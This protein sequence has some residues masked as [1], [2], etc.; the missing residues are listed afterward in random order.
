MLRPARPISAESSG[1][2]EGGS[3]TVAGAPVSEPETELQVEPGEPEVDTLDPPLTA[4]RLP[5]VYPTEEPVVE[6]GN[7][8]VTADVTTPL[9]T[10][11][12]ANVVKI[13][14][15]LLSTFVVGDPTLDAAP[16][17][18]PETG[19]Q[20]EPEVDTL[21]GGPTLGINPGAAM[22][23]PVPT[24]SPPLRSARA[25]APLA[26]SASPMAAAA[27]TVLRNIVPS[28]AGCFRRHGRS[29]NVPPKHPFGGRR[30]LATNR[31]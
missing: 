14:E 31:R 4:A 19:L 13:P 16:V 30:G 15:K 7:A 25:G 12:T 9:A 21:V 20:V 23:V 17:S 22:S 5:P 8:D 10:L 11:S 2:G 27:S 3:G 6:V 24:L 1:N 26:P 29:I 18:E 28:S